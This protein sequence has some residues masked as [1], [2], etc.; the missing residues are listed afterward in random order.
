MSDEQASKIRDL[1]YQSESFTS[2]PEVNNL[3][4]QSLS[5]TLSND[6]ALQNQIIA[7][8]TENKKLRDDWERMAL[9]EEELDATSKRYELAKAQIA[10][11]SKTIQVF[12]YFRISLFILGMQ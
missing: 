6:T 12:D 10:A 11:S 7:L 2:R 5:T 3:Q 1:T 9:L 8:Q 4:V